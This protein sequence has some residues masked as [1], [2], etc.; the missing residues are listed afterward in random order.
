MIGVQVEDM[1]GNG[2]EMKYSLGYYF[3]NSHNEYLEI[4]L[5]VGLIGLFSYLSVIILTIVKNFKRKNSLNIIF[6]V[7]VIAY[8]MQSFF[9]V[10]QPVVIPLLFAFLGLSNVKDITDSN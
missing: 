2:G 3:T 10:M 7:G 9:I 4:L 5:N 1:F 6:T 8:C